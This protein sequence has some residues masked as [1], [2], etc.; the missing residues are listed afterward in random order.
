[1][2]YPKAVKFLVYRKVLFLSCFQ[3][4]PVL[5]PARRYNNILVNGLPDW[6][7]PVYYYRRVR[8]MGLLELGFLLT[9]IL[10]VGQFL[11]VW[12]IYFEKRFEKVCCFVVWSVCIEKR[13]KKVCCLSSGPYALR[14]TSKKYVVC[15]L[16]CMH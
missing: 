14:S 16:V 1:M 13:F 6:R 3:S 2:S 15:R 4:E 11:V 8:K 7:Q 10:T 9:I 12:S 5:F